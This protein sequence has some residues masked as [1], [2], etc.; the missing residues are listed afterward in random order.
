[1]PTSAV[2]GR[3]SIYVNK[4]FTKRIVELKKPESDAILDVLFRLNADAIDAQIRVRWR[5]GSLVLWDNRRT[6]HSE[7]LP[8]VLSL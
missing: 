1:M 4:G 3:E 8:L 6:L 7:S 2:T 5:A